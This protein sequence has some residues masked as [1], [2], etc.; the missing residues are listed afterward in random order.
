MLTAGEST[1]AVDGAGICS[2]I[3]IFAI[4]GVFLPSISKRSA[5]VYWVLFILWIVAVIGGSNLAGPGPLGNAIFAITVVIGFGG[6]IVAL[7][8]RDYESR[9]AMKTFNRRRGARV[10]R[11]V[12]L[13]KRP[14]AER[15]FPHR[16]LEFS[17]LTDGQAGRTPPMKPLHRLPRGVIVCLEMRPCERPARPDAP[18]PS[19]P[20]DLYRDHEALERIGGIPP[21]ERDSLGRFREPRERRHWSR[22][23]EIE[24]EQ[25][26][27]A[28]LLRPFREF[29][30]SRGFGAFALGAVILAL[31][32]GVCFF[33]S[34]H[35]VPIISSIVGLIFGSR[36]R[37]SSDGFYAVPGAIVHRPSF[38]FPRASAYAFTPETSAL[39]IDCPK[40]LVYVP[41]NGRLLEVADIR[42]A[43]ALVKLW[44]SVAA[45]PPMPVL[46]NFFDGAT[47]RVA[48]PNAPEPR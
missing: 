30:H 20:L 48:R 6:P 32:I 4:R 17:L 38:T 35:L 29:Y 37:A 45:R 14:D 7:F 47:I 15:R 3:R 1:T 36:A 18:I 19:E 40:S 26:S 10:N 34:H 11:L 2:R 8:A 23:G 9:V 13:L 22:R 27:V 28:R 42:L 44:C 16:A 21:L 39:V 46:S 43:P 31:M 12:A 41:E 25:G 33:A 5:T 24:H